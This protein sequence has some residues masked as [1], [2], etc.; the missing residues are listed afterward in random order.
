MNLTTARESTL[1]EVART[2]LWVKETRLRFLGL[3]EVG[4]RMTV[5]RLADGT[6]FVHSP[7]RLDDQTRVELDSH[8]PVAFVVSPNK[9]HH[10]F[11]GDYATAYP[12]ARIYA[13]P[14]LTK[15]RRDVRF[16]GE[17]RDTPE[18]AWAADLDQAMFLGHPWLQEVVFLHRQSKT[19]IVADILQNFHEES[20]FLTRVYARLDGLYKQPRFPRDFRWTMTNRH[21]ARESVKRILAWDFE[22]IVLAHGR[23]IETGG[24]RIFADAFRWLFR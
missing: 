11:I 10:M 9:L 13:S 6:M 20:P 18:E 19:L 4:G 16:D 1:R 12:R 21:A 22:R 3:V 24:K 14:G 2:E 8:G 7:V 15:R 23:A 5:I 17:L